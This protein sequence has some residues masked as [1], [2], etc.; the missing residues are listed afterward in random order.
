MPI[1]PEHRHLYPREW[2]EIRRWILSRARYRCEGSPA[3]PACRAKDRERHPVTGSRVVLTIAH[4][5]HDPR[6]NDP[7]N[8]R[9]WCNRCHLTYDAPHHARTRQ[10]T[11][12]AARE[13]GGQLRL[14]ALMVG[15]G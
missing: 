4:L 12:R 10:R 6:N 11:I 13:D 7:T 15:E 9:A 14:S 2:A 5:D 3:Y 8:L 1:R